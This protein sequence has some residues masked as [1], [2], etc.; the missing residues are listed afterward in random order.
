MITMR[1]LLTTVRVLGM[2]SLA[3][4]L[5]AWLSPGSLGEWIAGHDDKQPNIGT[6]KSQ[7]SPSRNVPMSAPKSASMA[8]TD[9]PGKV[10]ALPD[11][12]VVSTPLKISSVQA[13]QARWIGAKYHVVPAAIAVLVVEA[14][15]LSKL[16]RLSPNL[17]IAVMAIE[18]NFHPYIQSEAGAQGLMQVMP[19]IHARRYEKFGGKSSFLDPIVSLR[20]G[21]EVLRDCIKLK[22]G[23]ETEGLRFYFGGGPTSDTYIEKVQAEQQR[24]NQ[25]ASGV[26]VPTN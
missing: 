7:A 20:V 3:L 21:A 2:L 24:L 26:P 23:S 15:T 12:T 10:A 11:S 9:S 17:L 16:Y 19:V 22:D 1:S 6:A 8:P 18:S 14:D 13:A 5:Y 4:I 25:V